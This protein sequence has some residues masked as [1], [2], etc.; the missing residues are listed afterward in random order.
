MAFNYETTGSVEFTMQQVFDEYHRVIGLMSP[1][2]YDKLNHWREKGMEPALLAQAIL[3]VENEHQRRVQANEPGAHQ[4]RRI[5][6][7]EGIL[8]NWYNDGLR[9]YRDW[10]ARE[11]EQVQ[12]ALQRGSSSGGD[13]DRSIG[14]YETTKEDWGWEV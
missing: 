5:S 2:H 8:R 6:Y 1:S 9:T 4:I 10:D 3:S 12:M 14:S 7:L 13:G 11:D